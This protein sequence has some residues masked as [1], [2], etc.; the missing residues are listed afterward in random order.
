[1]RYFGILC[2]VKAHAIATTFTSSGTTYFNDMLGATLGAKAKRA[3]RGLSPSAPIDVF[4]VIPWD[5][6]APYGRPYEYGHAW[7]SQILNGEGYIW[8]RMIE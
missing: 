6:E 4:N 5:L 8:A 3:R 1:M 7:S 2:A